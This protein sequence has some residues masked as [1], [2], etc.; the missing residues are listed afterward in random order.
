MFFKSTRSLGYSEELLIPSSKTYGM[1]VPYY[2][3]GVACSNNLP[4]YSLGGKQTS[5]IR[6]YMHVNPTPGDI[7]LVHTM[8]LSLYT[9]LALEP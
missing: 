7:Y 1:L 9:I 3:T 2:S 6:F 4:Q 8:I 5:D